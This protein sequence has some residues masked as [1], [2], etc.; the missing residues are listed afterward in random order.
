MP[1]HA[2]KTEARRRQQQP[3]QPVQP[4][5]APPSIGRP[6]PI[7]PPPQPVG[8]TIGPP[9]VRTIPIGGFPG[10]PGFRVPPPAP[11]QPVGPTIAPPGIPSFGIGGPRPGDSPPSVGGPFRLPP[12]SLDPDLLRL[13]A[14][15]Q[16]VGP[17]VAPPGIPGFGIGTPVSGRPVGGFP[18]GPGFQGP[19]NFLGRPTAVGGTPTS[20]T[21]NPGPISGG[22]GS[23]TATIPQLGGPTAAAPQFSR[24]QVLQQLA[25]SF[26][27]KSF[28]GLLPSQNPLLD[29]I[30]SSLGMPPQDFRQSLLNSFPQGI[31]PNSLFRGGF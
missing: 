22:P 29:S 2:A 26:T 23:P 13:P 5:I 10:G 24:S 19:G 11:P 7:G 27:P 31:N 1:F 21:F 20:P 25:R 16:P 6:R 3:V 8:P 14:P 9:G 12:P 17:T 4:R 15:G 18:S 30:V 28:F